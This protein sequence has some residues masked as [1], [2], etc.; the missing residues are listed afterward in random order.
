[1]TDFGGDVRA[2]LRDHFA[3]VGVSAAPDVAT[4]TFV[5]VPPVDV[6][7]FGPDPLG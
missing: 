2:H 4:V 6:L 5:G 1:M 7:K 3:R